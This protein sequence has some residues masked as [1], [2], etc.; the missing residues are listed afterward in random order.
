MN[1]VH[2]IRHKVLVEQ[3][4]RREVALQ[5]GVSR[6]TVRRYVD[7][8]VEPEAKPRERQR[9]VYDKAAGR[10]TALLEA[11]KG[12]T[13]GK[14]R[15]TAKRLHTML[16]NEGVSVGYTLVKQVV[17]EWR[18]QRREV[19]VPL[20][21]LPGDLAEVDF[22]EVWADIDGQRRKAHMFVMRLMHSGRDF[23]WLYE[24]QDQVSF[25]DGH[26]RAFEHFGGVAHRIAYDNLKAAVRRMLVGSERV[27]TARFAALSEH[28]LFEPCF[29]RP[30][31]GHDKGGVEVRGRSIRW[32]HLVP[33]PAGDAI[34]TIS[35]ALLAQL[36]ATMVDKTNDAGETIA[37]RFSDEAPRF[38]PFSRGPFR[39]AALYMPRVTRRS[40]V[41]VDGARYS[42][43]TEWASLEVTAYVEP[44]H[45][46]LV[47]PD[48]RRVR[49]PR[50]RRGQR[51]VDYR[52][53]LGELARKPQ[54]LRQVAHELIGSLGEP[55]QGAWR[56]L[57]DAHGPKQAARHFA[58]LL[59]AIETMG[60]RD[61]RDALS[62][63]LAA[64]EPPLFALRAQQQPVAPLDD[65]ALPDKLRAI[66]VKAA[67]AQSYDALLDGGVR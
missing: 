37:K 57:V 9:P 15:L 7:E 66:D 39:A 33:I 5:M 31:T 60:E 49:H 41:R 18:R 28:Y 50:M 34:E 46:E 11:S 24:R 23:A 2:V 10:I 54:A 53:Y 6:N 55:Y 45:V 44:H 35:G 19:Y 25:L 42:V 22:F 48:G 59:T 36:D 13:K 61:L 63:T 40:L 17:R 51:S 26:V 38:L 32:D 47:G 29:A 56:L 65:N 21:Y 52:H 43:W 30:Y 3:R 64:G 12:W 58:R 8:G 67:S 14:Q 27:L 1:Q 16:I 20:C 4:S 62:V